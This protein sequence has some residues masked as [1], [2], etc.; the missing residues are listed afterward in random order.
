M[1]WLLALLAGLPSLA[2]AGSIK[3]ICPH[4]SA[5]TAAVAVMVKEP[6]TSIT[7]TI[8]GDTVTF[9]D[10]EPGTSYELQVTLKDGTV[11]QGIDL[12]WY[13]PVPEKKNP[14]TLDDDDRQQM[15]DVAK[16]VLS[17]YNINDTVIVRGN[18]NRAVVL[19]NLVRDKGFHSDTGDEVIWRPELWYYEN[20][21]GGWEKVLQTDRVVRR[22]RFK[23]SKEYHDVVD[24]LQW[25][26]ELGGVKVA[27]DKP[28]VTV[29]VPEKTVAALAKTAVVIPAGTAA[30]NHPHTPPVHST[31][32]VGR[33]P[34][35][36][37]AADRV[38]LP[39]DTFPSAPDRGCRCRG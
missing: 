38:T 28:D 27:A 16:K 33:S 10:P 34:F 24:H 30:G 26:P 22:V 31:F 21:H 15:D 35:A 39:F 29:T 32:S 6:R 17:F 1:K 25:V 18:H 7:G 13:S 23:T 4:G 14:Q 12:S 8:A 36:F 5:P 19:M 11:D 2:F 3:L 37:P 20:H 9:A